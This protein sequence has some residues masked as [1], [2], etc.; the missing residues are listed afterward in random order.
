MWS[1][2]FVANIKAF[3]WVGEFMN[4]D[5]V[6]EIVEAK[7]NIVQ[8][9]GVRL[10]TTAGA[11]TCEAEM[12]VGDNVRQPF[13]YAAGGALLALA[14][15]LA[16]AGSMVLRPGCSCVG[17]NVSGNHLKPVAEGDTVK[18]VA[19]I[20]SQGYKMHVWNVDMFDGD[21]VLASTARVTNYIRP[22]EEK[23]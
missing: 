15:L 13:G 20:V 9:L 18:A 8:T 6:R 23:R 2:Q 21:G 17:I 11:D 12:P 22:I 1:V 14:E 10:L 4:L 5:S 7:H 16:G 19:R 3:S